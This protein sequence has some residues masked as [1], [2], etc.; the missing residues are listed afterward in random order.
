MGSF[1]HFD[2]VTLIHDE[3]RDDDWFRFQYIRRTTMP[4]FSIALV[5]LDRRRLKH[6]EQTCQQG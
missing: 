4:G 1:N 2:R 3:R 5:E 6:E